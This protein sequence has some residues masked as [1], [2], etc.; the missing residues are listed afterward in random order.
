MT[1][2]ITQFDIEVLHQVEGGRRRFRDPAELVSLKRLRQAGFIEGSRAECLC[3]VE[4][5][6]NVE[7]SAESKTGFASLAGSSNDR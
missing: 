1:Q 4:H 5:W 6:D 7:L 3:G 2:S